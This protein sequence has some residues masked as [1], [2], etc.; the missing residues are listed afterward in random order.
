MFIF[1]IPYI[2]NAF[3][4]LNDVVFSEVLITTSRRM[5]KLKKYR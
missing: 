4:T 5:K 3:K 2:L 1:W